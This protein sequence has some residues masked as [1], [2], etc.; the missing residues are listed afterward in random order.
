MRWPKWLIGLVVLGLL[1]V[2]AVLA[3]SVG[4]NKKDAWVCEEGEWVKYG[5]P[6][7]SRPRTPCYK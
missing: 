2:W 6:A 7:T 4:P 3:K 5:E 1:L